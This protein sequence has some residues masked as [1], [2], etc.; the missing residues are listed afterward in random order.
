MA[1]VIFFISLGSNEEDS[2][3][4]IDIANKKGDLRYFPNH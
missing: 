1:Y 4:K 2:K 3:K